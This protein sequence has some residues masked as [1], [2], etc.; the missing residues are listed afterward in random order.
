MR[1]KCPLD[2]DISM[3]HFSDMKML[4]EEYCLKTNYPKF[5]GYLERNQAN[6]APELIRH[7][8]RVVLSYKFRSRL[9]DGA[10]ERNRGDLS[11]RIVLE[12]VNTIVRN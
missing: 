8:D 6:V 9:A 3:G 12:V 1:A 10:C 11:D 2:V 4:Y 7:G 5:L